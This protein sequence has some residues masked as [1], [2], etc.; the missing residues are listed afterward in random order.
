MAASGGRVASSVLL[1]AG[2]FGAATLGLYALSQ[3][4]PEQAP[5]EP[6]FSCVYI[7][8]KWHV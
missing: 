8:F 3:R 6:P 7:W 4:L 1:L 5:G 2:L